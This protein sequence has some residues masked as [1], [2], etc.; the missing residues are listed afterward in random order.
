MEITDVG[1]ECDAWPKPK[2]I[3][4]GKYTYTKVAFNIVKVSTDEGVT[5]I[6]WG[7]GT[8]AT[9]PRRGEQRVS[10]SFQGDVDRRRSVHLSPHLGK[11]VVAK[12]RWPPRHVHAQVARATGIPIAIGKNEYTRYGFRD[13][14]EHESAAIFNADAQILGG[15]TEFMNVAALAAAQD[16]RIAPHGAQEV[17]IHIVAAIS[18]R[19]HPRILPRNRRAASR[20]VVRRTADPR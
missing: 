10:R 18:K 16:L 2:P 19:S 9:P 4:N 13:L 1:V 20:A 17:H 14:I 12:D 8:A 5:G 3:S 6:G 7:G 11:H 15:I